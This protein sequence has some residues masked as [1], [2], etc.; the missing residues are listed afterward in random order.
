VSPLS[1]PL[2]RAFRA[3]RAE[4]VVTANILIDE[5]TLTGR[6]DLAEMDA[7]RAPSSACA[8]GVPLRQEG[9]CH[10]SG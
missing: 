2:K 5:H 9:G 1:K 6:M 4:A 3:W 8:L 10:A 7:L